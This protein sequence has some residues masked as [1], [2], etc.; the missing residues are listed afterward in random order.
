MEKQ[1][2]ERLSDWCSGWD[3]TLRSWT[4]DWRAEEAGNVSMG[5]DNPWRSPLWAV[6]HTLYISLYLNIFIFQIKRQ[7]PRE[8]KSSSPRPYSQ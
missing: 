5:W 2:D 7:R 3:K 8:I 4:G 1:I 6:R